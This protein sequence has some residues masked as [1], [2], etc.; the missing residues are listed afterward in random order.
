MAGVVRG[1]ALL[2]VERR[3]D[4]GN[5]AHVGVSR[6]APHHVPALRLPRSGRRLRALSRGGGLAVHTKPWT[7]GAFGSACSCPWSPPDSSLARARSRVHRAEAEQQKAT[8][9]GARAE[10]RERAEPP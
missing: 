9:A 5:P 8:T 10:R 2:P 6:G 7:S 4:L 3:Q 1:P